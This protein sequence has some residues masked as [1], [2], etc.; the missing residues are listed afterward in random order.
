MPGPGLTLI[1]LANS[2]GLV[3]PFPLAAGDV[4]AS[5]FRKVFLGLF[6]R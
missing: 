1:L 3:K 5:P 4:T 2:N 6:M